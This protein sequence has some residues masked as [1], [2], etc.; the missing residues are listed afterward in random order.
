MTSPADHDTIRELIP[1]AALSALEET[2]MQ[3]V[4]SHAAT[5]DEC[6]RSLAEYRD[7]VVALDAAAPTPD[8]DEDA[9]RAVR[10][11]LLL[12]ARAERGTGPRAR[13]GFRKGAERWAGW[14][15]AA[16]FAGLLLVHHS[17]HRPLNYGWLVAGALMV[18]LVAVVVYA[19]VQAGRAAALRARIDELAG[20]A[21]AG[22]REDPLV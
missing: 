5:C 22:R 19:R 10:E 18:A 17:V 13:G 16:G 9:A 11:R 2:E 15:V 21:G 1:A 20:G 14:A 6:S 12:R 4:L 7:V 8:R 3:E